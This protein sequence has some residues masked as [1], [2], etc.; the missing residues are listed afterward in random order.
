M[1][2]QA[3]RAILAHDTGLLVGPPGIGKTVLATYLIAQRA[4]STLI[5][6]HRKPLLDQWVAQLAMSL[7]VDQRDV[8]Q[9]GG[10]KRRASGR[11]T[12]P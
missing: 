9:I 12:W 11:L 7:G 2:E 3:A 8:G 6:V 4:R 10:G 5:L 1:Q